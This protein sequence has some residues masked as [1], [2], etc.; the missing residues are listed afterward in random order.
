MGKS[1]VSEMFLL[2]KKN[3]LL[4]W[5]REAYSRSVCFKEIVTS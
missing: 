5:V 4:C 2:E 1:P 3:L